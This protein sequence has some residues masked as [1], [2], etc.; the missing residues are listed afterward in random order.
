M[1][2]ESKISNNTKLNYDITSKTVNTSG[3]KIKDIISNATIEGYDGSTK[4]EI[5][6]VSNINLPKN[7]GI[8]DPDNNY[9]D[10]FGGNQA[11]LILNIEDYIS[12]P[13]IREIITKYYPEADL[14]ADNLEL[15]FYRMNSVGC[16]YI[17]AINTILRAYETSGHD[18][19]DFYARFGFP[20][21]ELNGNQVEGHPMIKDYNY[22]YLFLD[23]FLYCAKNAFGFN[24]LEEAIGNTEEEIAI[25]NGQAG[26]LALNDENFE[27]EGMNGSWLGD[28]AP[29]MLSY[30]AEKGIDL[31]CDYRESSRW[32]RLEPGTER[33]EEFRSQM[34]YEVPDGTPLN[35][36]ITVDDFRNFLNE[37]KQVIIS[38]K[39][40]TLYY[41]DDVDGNGKY[42]DIYQSNIGG[43]AMCVVG[44]TEDDK[45]IVSSW[46]NEYLFELGDPPAG[47]EFDER[48]MTDFIIYDYGSFD[49]VE[50]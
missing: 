16:G 27:I 14:S 15:L 6:N 8:F 24:T 5:V 45:L 37:G 29:T 49:P 44:V 1:K 40:F 31:N 7:D 21:Y 32:I 34:S 43:H 38:A 48:N 42:D 25:R 39:N 22:E 19:L 20:P 28:I 36:P 3:N 2:I 9:Y 41:P 12:N 11:E 33:Y 17:A 47:G 26:D 4:P 18:E 35:A 10:K 13:K 30:L 46:G 50:T 23:F